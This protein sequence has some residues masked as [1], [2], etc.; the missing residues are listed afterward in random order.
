MLALSQGMPG[1][2][3]HRQHLLD[4]QQMLDMVRAFPAESLHVVALH[5]AVFESKNMT[6]PWRLRT[7]SCP[8]HRPELDLVVTAPDGRLAAFC[9]GW[10]ANVG[11]EQRPWGQIE[12]LWVHAS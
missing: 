7:L 8:E 6:L 10:F 2:A 4:H 5:Q 9:V 11:A 3:G 12:P 1:A